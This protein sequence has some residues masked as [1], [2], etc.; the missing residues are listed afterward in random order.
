MKIII[1][2]QGSIVITISKFIQ[3]AYIVFLPGMKKVPVL[4]SAIYICMLTSCVTGKYSSTNRDH[5]K[6]AKAFSKV[7]RSEPKDSLVADSMK[8]P[9]HWIGTSNFGIRRPNFVI[10]HHTGQNSCEQTLHSFTEKQTQVSAHY[11][12]CKDG[13]LHHMLNNYLRAWHAGAAKW[14]NETDINSCSI[15]IEIDNNGIDTFTHAQLNTLQ[16]LLA[17]LKKQYNI[18]APNFIGHADVAPGR[19]VDPSVHFPWKDLAEKGFG[20]WYGDTT[21][22]FVPADFNMIYGLRI[23][24]YDI[25]NLSSAIQ[26]FRRHFLETDF[27]GEFTEP[28]KKV[29]YVLMQKFL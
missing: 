16:G 11:V 10:I 12:I 25:S 20:L 22:V 1:R 5:K 4:I 3:T 9:S 13:T 14:G 24:G 6:Q 17:S 2:T 23:I 19:K 26:S 28:E 8:F 29:L 7:I 27:A 18:P 21:N 15:G